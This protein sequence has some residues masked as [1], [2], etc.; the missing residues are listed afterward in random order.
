M[1]LSFGIHEIPIKKA[2]GKIVEYL[3]EPELE[4]LLKQ[5]DL[6]KSKF[7]KLINLAKR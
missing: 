5:T 2:Q 4:I 3:S 7:A 1:N 6:K